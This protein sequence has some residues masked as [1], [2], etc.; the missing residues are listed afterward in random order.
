RCPTS[1]RAPNALYA[2]WPCV[3]SPRRSCRS[4]RRSSAEA[5]RLWTD[6]VRLHAQ[7]RA[8]GRWLSA[9]ALEQATTGGRYALHRQSVQALCQKFAANLEPATALRTQDKQELADT[10]HIQTAY[11]H[12]PK[13]DPTVVWKD[14][15]L[16]VVPSGQLRLPT[17]SQRPPVLL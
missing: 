9:G 7:T 8:Q 13:A 10:G 2:S 12:R 6:L 1:T 17:G 15:A 5:G 4:V 3:V 16:T 11:P 14:Q